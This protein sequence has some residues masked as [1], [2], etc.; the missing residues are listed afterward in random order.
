[1]PSAFFMSD[2]GE[3]EGMTGDPALET[4]S[5]RG[6]V[7][8]PRRMAVTL[9]DGAQSCLLWDQAGA[10]AP[11]L[12]FAHA[13]GF[14]AYT[15]RRI[16]APLSD[17]VRII[18]SD[19]RGHGA[20][21]L[22]ADPQTHHN[23]RVYRD[24]LLML[25]DQL[26][27]GERVV[28]SGHSMGGAASL[29]AAAERPDRVAGLV[30]LDPVILPRRV[31]WLTQ[32]RQ[33]LGL[34]PLPNPLI[35]GARA[36]RAQWPDH[37]TMIRAYTGRGAFKTWPREIIADYVTGGTRVRDDG[38]VELACAPAWEAANFGAQGHD[39]WP[40]ISKLMCPLIL[41]RGTI[42][43]TCPEFIAARIRAR[44]PQCDDRP[45]AGASHF[46]PMEHPDQ[47][48]AAILDM[49]DQSQRP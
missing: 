31:Y 43:S 2:T 13:N 42:N 45:L 33:W 21:T 34:G 20:S 22:P 7:E 12:H 35:T 11:L 39:P 49:L 14:N 46:V 29:L 32:M 48:Q 8:E 19:L 1:M 40:D 15:Y 3:A 36:R 27:P 24:D 9:P 30:L 25:L 41:L 47:V 16:L 37:E 10:G 5:S 26:A 44:L 38:S 18:A 4:E 17:R 23:W 6:V 28:L